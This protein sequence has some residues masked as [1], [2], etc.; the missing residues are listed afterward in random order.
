MFTA[1]MRGLFAGAAILA[2]CGYAA[3]QESTV[4]ISFVSVNDIDRMGESRD[5]RGGVARLAAV[6]AAETAENPTPTPS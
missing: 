6:L 5:G 2:T 3:A 1:S 4:T